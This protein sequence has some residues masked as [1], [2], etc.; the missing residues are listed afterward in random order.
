[1]VSG[2]L[3]ASGELVDC[4]GSCSLGGVGAEQVRP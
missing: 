4:M 3:V 2:G 1:V